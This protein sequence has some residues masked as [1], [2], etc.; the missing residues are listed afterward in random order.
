MAHPLGAFYNTAHGTANAILLPTVMEFNSPATGTKYRDI[1]KAL[2]VPGVDAMS[3]D[4]Y[5]K[6]AVDAVR[7]LSTDV[8]IPTTLK[9]I[10]KLEDVPELARSAFIDPCKPGN[11]RDVTVETL[12]ELYRK[13]L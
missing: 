3:Q 1:A 9:G 2:G 7:Q 4:E 10:A 6:A 11:P 12:E 13:L 5:R 8:G